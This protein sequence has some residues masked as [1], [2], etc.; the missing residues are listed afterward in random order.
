MPDA[1]DVSIYNDVGAKCSMPWLG[2][3]FSIDIFTD[4]AWFVFILTNG[5][6]VAV[7]IRVE[8]GAVK[9]RSW[10]W[11]TRIVKLCLLFTPEQQRRNERPSFKVKRTK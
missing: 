2:R 3:C 11:P 6:R 8:S 7:A 1:P 10:S 5:D 9:A 4:N